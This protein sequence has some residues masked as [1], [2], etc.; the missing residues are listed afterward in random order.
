ML[1]YLANKFSKMQMIKL[2]MITEES[3]D[4]INT[5]ISVKA[6]FPS[7]AM[8]YIEE[9]IDLN[10]ELIRHPLAT[11]MAK[12]DSDSMINAFIPPNARVIIDRSLIPKNGDIV[13]AALNG[14]FTLKFLKQNA[15]K[16]WLVPA[17]SKY[18]P[19]AITEES[20]LTIWGVVTQILIDPKDVRS[21]ML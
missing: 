17:N 7:P 18:Q 14:E 1:H 3:F 4:L 12:C 5:N 8:D 6:G 9:R 16:A 19:M 2:E 20:D 13:V 21:C 10:R 15:V 11:F